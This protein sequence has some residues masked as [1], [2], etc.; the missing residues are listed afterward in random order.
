MHIK[1]LA[2]KKKKRIVHS[3]SWQH[4]CNQPRIAT[5][6]RPQPKY[7][8]NNHRNKCRKRVEITPGE[9]TPKIPIKQVSLQ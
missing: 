6:N 3:K 4:E 9:T 8:T 1:K 5:E 2:L 7:D